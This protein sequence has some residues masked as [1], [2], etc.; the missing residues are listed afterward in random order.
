MRV[1]E[2]EDAHFIVPSQWALM[3]LH[4]AEERVMDVSS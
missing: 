1:K 4:G 3:V 2:A